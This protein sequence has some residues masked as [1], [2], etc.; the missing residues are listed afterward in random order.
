[1][2]FIGTNTTTPCINGATSGQQ[3]NA[4]PQLAI[5]T[6]NGGYAVGV[7]CY[8]NGVITTVGQTTLF[9]DT[10]APNAN[11]FSNYAAATTTTTTL[12]GTLPGSSFWVYSGAFVQPAVVQPENNGMTALIRVSRGPGWRWRAPPKGWKRQ[13]GILLKAA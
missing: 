9:N 5:T 12:T 8:D 7:C 4:A 10:G 1:M 6:A 13:G 3:N 11:I 2:S